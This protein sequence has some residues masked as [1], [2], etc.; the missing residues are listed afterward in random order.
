[1]LK[2]DSDRF[3]KGMI[4]VSIISLFFVFVYTAKEFEYSHAICKD[5]TISYSMGSGTCSWHGGIEKKVF[6]ELEKEMSFKEIV[7]TLFM[8]VFLGI[9]LG[10]LV[11]L[12]IGHIRNR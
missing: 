10:I 6:N 1:M 3:F 11:Y 4:I 8:S 7:V 5:G 2:T 9:P 12:G